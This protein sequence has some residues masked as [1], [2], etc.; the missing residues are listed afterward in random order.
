MTPEKCNGL[1]VFPPTEFY[2]VNFDKWPL[3]LDVN[4]ADIVL[5]ATENSSV[6]HLWNHHW[7]NRVV[8]KSKTNRKTAYEVIAE[9]N[10]PK[11]FE[12][13]GDHI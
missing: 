11:V 7:R 5:K 1:K 4:T 3:F 2:A 9:K 8:T 13:S 10:C 6:I 12:A